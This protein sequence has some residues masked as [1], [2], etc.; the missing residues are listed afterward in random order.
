VRVEE[1]EVQVSSENGVTHVEKKTKR[2]AQIDQL[3]HYGIELQKESQRPS[4]EV[5]LNHS[6]L[7]WVHYLGYFRDEVFCLPLSQVP[8]DSLSAARTSEAKSDVILTSTNSVPWSEVLRAALGDGETSHWLP[9]DFSEAE[10]NLPLLLPLMSVVVVDDGKGGRAFKLN[11]NVPVS[12]KRFF[13]K[14]IA[15][16]S[17]PVNAAAS[18]AARSGSSEEGAGEGTK[19]EKNLGQRISDRRAKEKTPTSAPKS[20]RKDQPP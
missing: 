17:S 19:I 7:S 3:I 10:K 5:D 11:G 4:A 18:T 12:E 6:I 1:E 15:S 13:R 8:D 20:D 9:M 2:F 14:S 16:D